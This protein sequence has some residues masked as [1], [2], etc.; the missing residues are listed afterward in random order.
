[1]KEKFA[2][3]VILESENEK[4]LKVV[5]MLYDGAINFLNKAIAYAGEGGDT[6]KKNRYTQKANEII[7][8]LD[9]ILDS[10]AGGD[11]TKNLKLLYAFMNR[12]LIEAAA[13]GNTTGL[14]EVIHML[15]DLRESWQ[16]VDVSMSASA[17]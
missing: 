15:S 5:L 3:T 1:M 11:V 10:T 2:E 12:H 4:S 8:G 9:S 14:T 16:F 13:N 6:K 7:V 17:A